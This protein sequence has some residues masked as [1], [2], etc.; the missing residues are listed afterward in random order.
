MVDDLHSSV[1]LD[2]QLSHDDVV[3][4][5]V[6]IGP[7]IRLVPPAKGH[8]FN[9]LPVKRRTRAAPGSGNVRTGDRKRISSARQHFFK[10]QRVKMTPAAIF[11]DSKRV[12]LLITQRQVELNENE[13]SI[14]CKLT[15]HQLYQVTPTMRNEQNFKRQTSIFDP[16]P[17]RSSNATQIGFHGMLT[18]KEINSV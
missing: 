11:L 10:C 14:S 7:G 6:D 9:V 13:C 2:P 17:V 3:D 5:A 15:L 1:L 12:I 16:D 8:N 4:A 18:H